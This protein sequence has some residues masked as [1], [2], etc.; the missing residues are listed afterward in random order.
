MTNK[1]TTDWEDLDLE[2]LTPPHPHFELHAKLGFLCRPLTA[3]QFTNVRWAALNG[4]PGD[5]YE[6]AIAYAVRDWRGVYKN[7]E[8]VKFSQKSIAQLLE[9]ARLQEFFGDLSKRICERS[10]LTEDETKN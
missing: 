9:D 1:L 10:I 7:G 5:A 8:P 6:K 3:P 2:A 4:D